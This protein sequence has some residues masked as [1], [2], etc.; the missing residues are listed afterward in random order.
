M[1]LWS[2]EYFKNKSEKTINHQTPPPTIHLTISCHWKK[3]NKNL[4]AGPLEEIR[5]DIN[6]LFNTVI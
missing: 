1:S 4:K 3:T 2:S 6:F 5:F